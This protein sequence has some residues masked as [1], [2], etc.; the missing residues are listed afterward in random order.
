MKQIHLPEGLCWRGGTI[1]IN[2][3]MGGRRVSRSCKT[4]SVPE[5]K[6]LLATIRSQVRVAELTGEKPPVFEQPVDLAAFV[7][8]EIAQMRVDGASAKTL[9]KYTGVM[10]AFGSLLP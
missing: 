3:S 9:T 7:A 5:A 8:D 2:T 10:E 1:Y 6:R 4:T